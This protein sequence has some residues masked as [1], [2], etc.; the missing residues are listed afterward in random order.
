MQ[1]SKS[2]KLANVCYD[3]RGP[4]LRHAKRL[5]EEGHRI[6]KLNIGNPAPF[7]FEA[8]EEILQDVILNLPT[9]QGYSDSRGLFSARKAV[10]HYTQTK[11]IPGVGIEDIYLGN[12]VSE[13]IVM[14]MQG[15]L[16]NGDEV[17]IPAPDYPLWTASVSLSGGKPVHYLCDEQ[18]DWYPDIEDIRSKITPNTRAMVVINPNNPTGAVYPREVLEQLAQV[19]REHNLILFADE[20][21]DKILYDG[22]VHESLAAVAPDV[23]CLTFNGLSKSY[24]VAGFRS[25]WMVISGPKQHATSY[26][27][28]LEILA[29]MRLCAN[30][31]AQHAIQT[32]L[33]G[34]QSINDLILP[35]GRL[36]EQ[37]DTAWELLNEIPGVSCTKPKG[38]LYLFPRLDPKVYPIHNDEKFVLDLLLQEKILIVQG[39]AFNWPWPDHF[40][41]VSLP[42][43]DDLEMA[44]GRIGNFLKS[45]RQ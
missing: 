42:R 41:I 19:A 43:K 36:L 28:G 12:G 15:L 2:N 4:V 32:A 5:E 45:Y 33:G 29:S 37:R 21:Y 25:G 11:N 27:E 3:I 30:V 6:L 23:L 17:L 38:A 22:A 24:R 10:M 18:S 44:I 1:V 40:R 20:I 34:Y 26:L 13:L 35:G 7:G 8:P 16:N 14:A 9:A 39:T 31:P